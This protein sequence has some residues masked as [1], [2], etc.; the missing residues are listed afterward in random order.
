MSRLYILKGL[1]ASGKSTRAKEILR[2]DGN[3]VRLNRDLMREMLHFNHWTGKK[4]QTTKYAQMVLAT[5]LLND[6]KNVLIDDTN[7]NPNVFAAWEGIAKV[8]KHKVEVVDLLN[9]PWQECIRRD[10]ERELQ[11]ERFVGDH[12]IINMA[13]QYGLYE[14]DKPDIICD[15]DGTLADITHRLH[16]VK[17]EGQKKDWGAFFAVS[18][19]DAPRTEVISLVQSKLKTHNVVLVSGR[20]DNYR[21]KTVQWLKLHRVSYQTLIMRKDS[22]SREDD[23]VKQDILDTYWPLDTKKNIELVIDDRPR[24]IAMW[25][26]N[27]LEVLDVGQGID[28]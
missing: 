24:V 26:K 28:F 1:P 21:D 20:P 14:F 3:C 5:S 25:R 22:D 2:K 8:G 6:K 10:N 9:V 13:R 11:G 12:V 16:H 27:G 19:L 18:L 17:T 7:L 23:I 15:I 4:E